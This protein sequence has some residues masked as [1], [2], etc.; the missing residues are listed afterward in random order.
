MRSDTLLV[1]MQ[2]LELFELV[3]YT[4][5]AGDKPEYFVRINSENALKKISENASYCSDTL[6][7][8]F[9]MHKE[10]VCYMKYFFTALK[11]DKERWKFIEK[12]FLGQ[13]KESY[14]ILVEYGL[15]VKKINRPKEE[16]E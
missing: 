3:D 15:K 12:Y 8:I 1:A 11:S 14:D 5:F 7:A 9:E 16:V 6:A 13:V 2:I 10:S 4:F